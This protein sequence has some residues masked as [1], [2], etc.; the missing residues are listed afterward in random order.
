MTSEIG[1][2]DLKSCPVCGKL[3]AK[4]RK[5]CPSCAPKYRM[6]TSNN[7]SDTSAT[8]DLPSLDEIFTTRAR[9]FKHIPKRA[10]PIWGEVFAKAAASAVHINSARAWT[11]LLMLPKCV[12]LTPPRQGKSNKHVTAEF[13]RHRCDRWLSGDRKELWADGPAARQGRRGARDSNP[14]GHHD[15]KRRQ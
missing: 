15:T 11:E 8:D 9:L 3:I 5:S 7:L 4:S 1:F 10:R 12:L 14:S 6:A 2:Y 13:V